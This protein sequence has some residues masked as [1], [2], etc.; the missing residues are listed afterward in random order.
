MDIINF[1]SQSLNDEFNLFKDSVT[2]CNDNFENYSNIDS[3]QFSKIEQLSLEDLS[4]EIQ[5]EIADKK[6]G[7]KTKIF[8]NDNNF[9]FF[10]VCEI[11]GDEFQEI[12]E[13]MIDNKLY[14]EKVQQLSQTYLKRLN[15]NSNIKLLIN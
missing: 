9:F 2:N 4:G 6:V 13:N 14:Y 11:S 10:I 12:D 15:R 5:E 7:E 1:S 3:I 8:K